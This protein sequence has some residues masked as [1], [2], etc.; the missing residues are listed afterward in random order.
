MH[1]GLTE[2]KRVCGA[3]A[4]QIITTFSFFFL[5]DLMPQ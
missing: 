1:E 5:N 4:N 3:A 2:E